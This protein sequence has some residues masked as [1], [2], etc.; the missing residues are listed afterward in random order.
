MT[1]QRIERLRRKLVEHKL[2]ALFVISPETASPTNRRYL[3]GFTGTSAYLLITADDVVLATDSRYWEQAERQAPECRILR[4]IGG[5]DKWLP[6][7]LAGQG[8]KRIAFEGA[9]IT[10]Q[11]HRAIRKEIQKLPESERPKLVA[12]VN[13]V[14]GLRLIKEPEEIAAIQAAIDIGDAA[15]AAVAE[16]I[17]P[18]W[19]EKQVAWEIE[20]Y[21]REHGGDAV[22]FP[23]IVGGG[24]WGAMAHAFPRDEALKK[25][26]G[27]VIDMGVTLDGYNSDLT[28]TIFLGEPDDTFKKV[29]DI[30]F[31]AQQT[32][33]ELVEEGMT[34]EDAHMLAHNVIDE[35]GYGDNFGHGLGHG[36]GM[37]VHE[38]PRVAKTSKDKLRDG[39]VF[40]IEPGI[41]LTEWGGVRIED[42]VV[43]EEGKARVMSH[44]PKLITA[45]L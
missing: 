34:G 8:G 42:I 30:V 29:Y 19:T 44:A 2:D 31:A 17:E 4:A 16:R 27:V 26:E 9:H 13:L 24:P 6:E 33:I 14:E 35:A 32:A 40:T 39:M 1:A 5:F 7:L 25:G 11:T 23:T 3:S 15:F 10:Y 41:Y 21:V 12:T 18:G 45:N 38:G 20:K 36:I 28:R 43:M 22:S 37:Q